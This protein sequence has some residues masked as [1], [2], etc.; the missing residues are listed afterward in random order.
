MLMQCI[1][2]KRFIKIN[3][4]E[5]QAGNKDAP[6]WVMVDNEE[7]ASNDPAWIGDDHTMTMLA[8]VKEHYGCDEGLSCYTPAP[9]EEELAEIERKRILNEEIETRYAERMKGDA[10]KQI[11]H[12]VGHGGQGM[13]RMIASTIHAAS[14]CM[15]SAPACDDTLLDYEDDYID[16]MGATIHGKHMKNPKAKGYVPQRKQMRAINRQYNQRSKRMGR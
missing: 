1:K 13:G 16:I 7:D 15:I 2:T 9:T 8:F 4:E 3:I 12:L 10:G 6:I 5:I 14:L 11:I